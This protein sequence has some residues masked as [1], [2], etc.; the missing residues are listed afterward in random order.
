ME[1]NFYMQESE[2]IP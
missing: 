1:V 2:S